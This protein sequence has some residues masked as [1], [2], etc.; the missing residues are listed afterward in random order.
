MTP[1]ETLR[2]EHRYILRA[3]GCAETA[4]RRIR[5]GAAVPVQDLRDLAR[6]FADYAD[7]CHH[8]KE[9]E[10][11]FPALE[12][13]GVPRDG[14][15]LAVMLAEHDEG[16]ECVGEMRRAVEADEPAPEQLSAWSSAAL[17]FVSLLRDHIGKEDH[18]LFRMAEDVLPAEVS[19]RLGDTF[20]KVET[21]EIGRDKHEELE[22]VAVRLGESYG[23]PEQRN[24]ANRP[25]CGGL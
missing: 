25:H 22:A 17:H 16:R 4:A 3:L 13:H 7:G 12:A 20:E 24:E 1:T 2:R 8:A 23:V 21:L 18:V 14:G 5:A 11:L 19:A 9:E 15:P 10:H 6:F